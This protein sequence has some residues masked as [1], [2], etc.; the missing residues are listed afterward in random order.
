MEQLVVE[1]ESLLVMGTSG[2]KALLFGH[3]NRAC[4]V[5]ASCMVVEVG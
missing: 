2:N 3:Y 1:E 5:P 4:V